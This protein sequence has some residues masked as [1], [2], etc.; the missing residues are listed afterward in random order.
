MT[1]KV[2]GVLL[3]VLMMNVLVDAADAPAKTFKIGMSQCN[4][5][6]PWRVQ[7]NADVK[8]AA[9]THPQIEM[10]FKDAQNDTLKQ[11]AQ[12]EEFVSAGV[13]LL[14]VSPKEAAPLTPSIAAA[15]QKGIPVIVL[16]RRLVGDE[17]TSFIGADNKLIGKAAG[18]WLVKRLGGKGKIVELKGLMTSTPGPELRVPGGDQGQWARSCFRGR[19]EMAGAGRAQG[20]GVRAGPL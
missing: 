8:K 9:D 6:E 2:L 14:I 13:D 12:I 4:L 1:K 15:M 17:Y 19:H 10:I 16:D 3:C 5:G 20:D 11:R 18:E 7:M